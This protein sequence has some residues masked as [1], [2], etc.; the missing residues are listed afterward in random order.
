MWPFCSTN[1]SEIIG[2]HASSG[3]IGKPNVVGYTRRDIA[4]SGLEVVAR[5]LTS[6]GVELETITYMLPMVMGFLPAARESH[7]GSE[8]VRGQQQAPLTA[9]NT[10]KQLQLMEDPGSTM[11]WP[12]HPPMPYI[13]QRNFIEELNIDRNRLKLRVG[14]FRAEPWSDSMRKRWK[15]G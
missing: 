1:E 15:K 13:W 9:G 3:T 14:I 10:K 2:I 6:A 11:P 8:K 5:I 12:A 7:Y 4:P